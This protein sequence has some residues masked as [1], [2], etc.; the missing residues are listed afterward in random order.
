M[1]SELEVLAIARG[2][3]STSVPGGSAAGT[4]AN[5]IVARANAE[6]DPLLGEFF[7]GWTVIRPGQS[8][9]G[10]R[11]DRIVVMFQLAPHGPERHKELVWLRDLSLGLKPGKRLEWLVT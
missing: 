11:F 10:M 6:T 1:K 3:R 9:G 7:P 5:A 4:A 2:G 8:K